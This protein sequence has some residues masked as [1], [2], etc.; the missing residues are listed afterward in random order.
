VVAAPTVV[1]P[2]YTPV[3]SQ[4]VA[5]QPS[6]DWF[7][8][9]GEITGG[10]ISPEA[11]KDWPEWMQALLGDRQGV[12]REE[13]ARAQFYRIPDAFL[14][15]ALGVLERER[16]FTPD[17]LQQVSAISYVA[18]TG[19]WKQA[20]TSYQKAYLAANALPLGDPATCSR[21]LTQLS[22]AKEY[23]AA[24][25][26][27]LMSQYPVDPALRAS[28]LRMIDMEEGLLK[29][30][31]DMVADHGLPAA[32]RL[33]ALMNVPK[34]ATS[35]E[36][37]AS[38]RGSELFGNAVFTGLGKG[39]ITISDPMVEEALQSEWRGEPEA[40]W[41]LIQRTERLSDLLWLQVVGA[42]DAG[43]A[44]AAKASAT[45]LLERYPES[46]YSGHAL[47]ALSSLG[48]ASAG[49]LPRLKIPS[50]VTLYNAGSLA[51]TAPGTDWPTP[52]DDLAAKG[53][54]DL[55]V[56]RADLVT[57][58]QVFLKA[59][60]FAGQQDL[61]SRYLS[62]E[63]KCSEESL[64]LLYP[65]SL[66]AVIDKMI[67][68]E[69]LGGQVEPAFVISV[70]KCESLFQPSASSSADAHGLM[71]LL[72]P[73]FG[74]MMGKQADIRD[75]LTN[76]RGGLRYFKQ[77][78][79][80]AGLDGLPRDVRYAYILAGYH[81]GEG[82]AKTWRIANETKLA[83][84]TD[85]TQKLLRIEAIPIYSTRQYLTRVLG[86]YEIYRRLQGTRAN[87]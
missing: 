61:V 65:Q 47:Y 43:N 45:A 22:Q 76:I 51:I 78:I 62:I 75:P 56:A 70:I 34:T 55:I 77:I 20:R 48:A 3:A 64:P 17:L 2:V 10:F 54:Y 32:E 84:T 40:P 57:Q 83:N 41:F 42:L 21:L 27:M 68:E 8:K 14:P 4:L 29:A 11:Q 9:G 72:K 12:S 5:I 13:L 1:A 82:R 71:Q 80:T 85:P 25:N 87:F 37:V 69:G 23:A 63:K 86:D 35:P 67:Q 18:D 15:R 52:F 79:K 50:D 6:Q 58:T 66:L 36:L 73:T 49:H 81:A 74:R 38:L 44:E 59:A 30:T 60:A 26:A 28:Y 39:W 7:L 31:P 33:V 19:S 16:I 53:R 46:F 24:R